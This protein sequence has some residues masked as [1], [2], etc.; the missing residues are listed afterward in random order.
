MADLSHS[1]FAKQPGRLAVH[2]I[3]VKMA[4]ACQETSSAFGMF[5]SVVVGFL[6]SSCTTRPSKSAT[7]PSLAEL[8][9][10]VVAARCVGAENVL[11]S[12]PT[13]KTAATQPC[14]P[15]AMND[16]GLFLTLGVFC[17]PR[18]GQVCCGT[19]VGYTPEGTVCVSGIS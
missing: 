6:Q 17:L 16:G 10:L 5:V 3:C 1:P 13:S 18:P 9:Q 2:S 19:A 8:D 7:M 14:P 12:P 4:Q 11:T 15:Y